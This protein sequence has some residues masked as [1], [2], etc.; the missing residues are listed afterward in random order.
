MY[1]SAYDLNL[2][3]GIAILPQALAERALVRGR[4]NQ[5][6]CRRLDTLHINHFNNKETLEIKLWDL[7]DL[8]RTLCIILL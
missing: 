4:G 1:D 3:V 2:I 8:I 6:K 5:G 7:I